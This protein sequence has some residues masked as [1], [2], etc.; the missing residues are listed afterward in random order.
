LVSELPVENLRW[1]CDPKILRAKSTEE[2]KPLEDLVGQPRAYQALMLGF[3]AKQ[4]GFN[5]FAAGP[6][7]TGENHRHH[8]L[9]RRYRNKD[10]D[11]VGLV[12]RA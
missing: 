1:N 8:G 11:A 10:A 4:Q 9:P 2:L 7:G 3:Y 6:T 5:V 12:L